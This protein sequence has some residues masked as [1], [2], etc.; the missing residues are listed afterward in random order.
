MTTLIRQ[1]KKQRSEAS[2][3]S[4][5]LGLESLSEEERQELR[6]QVDA[7][8]PRT[9]LAIDEAQILLPKEGSSATRKELNAYVLEGRNFGLSLWLATQRPKGAISNEARSQIDTFI[10]HRLSVQDDINAV[11]QMLQ[12]DIPDKIKI[13]QKK[14]DMA[15]WIRSLSVG[16]ALLSGNGLDRVVA[17]KIKPRMVAHG[18]E[19]F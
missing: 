13:G 18:G 3:M 9:I 2:Q 11:C 17:V 15:D 7:R 10:V 6:Q 19:A 4:R 5:R 1:L 14:G 16:E 12:N 8:V